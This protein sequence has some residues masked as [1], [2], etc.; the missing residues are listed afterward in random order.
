MA[1]VV[2]RNYLTYVLEL[3]ETQA[4]ALMGEGI[5]DFGRLGRMKDDLVIRLVDNCRKTYKTA[6]PANA[7]ARAQWQRLRPGIHISE[8]SC[9]KFRQLAFYCFHLARTGRAF[10]AGEAFWKTIS[11]FTPCSVTLLKTDLRLPM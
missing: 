9:T 5:A 3:P 7:A 1:N 11:F 8:E 4:R 6:P 2:F 10:Q